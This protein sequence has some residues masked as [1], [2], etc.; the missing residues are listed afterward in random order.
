MAMVKV[1]PGAGRVV[2]LTAG[3]KPLKA[4]GATV[5]RSLLIER[6]IANGDLVLEPVAAPVAAPADAEAAKAAPEPAAKA[7][8]IPAKANAEGAKS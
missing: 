4:T 6:W 2:R 8:S 1:Y 7:P 3:A 5:E